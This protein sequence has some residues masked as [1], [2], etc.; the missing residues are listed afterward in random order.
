MTVKRVVHT[1]STEQRRP[2]V[3]DCHLGGDPSQPGLAGTERSL[4][5]HDALGVEP[6]LGEHL[7]VAHRGQDVRLGVS[8]DLLAVDELARID[9]VGVE[10]L[11]LPVDGMPTVDRVRLQVALDLFVQPVDDL[12]VHLATRWCSGRT[13]LRVVRVLGRHLQR[14]TD[15]RQHHVAPRHGDVLQDTVDV[16]GGDGDLLVAARTRSDPWSPS[17]GRSRSTPSA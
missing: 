13:A 3:G 8:P 5:Q 14:G 7:G 11:H 6:E 12:L 1:W 10:E 2:S 17:T 9:L 15:E 4:Q 16:A